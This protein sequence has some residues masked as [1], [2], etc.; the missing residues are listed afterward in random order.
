MNK[1]TKL[2][3]QTI[4]FIC[5]TCIF[6]VWINFYIKKPLDSLILAILLSIFADLFLIL[7][8]NKKNNKYELK[9][10]E[11]KDISLKSQV[12]LY[13][14]KNFVMEFFEKALKLK[15]PVLNKCKDFFYIDNENG[16]TFF[17]P[18]YSKFS[19]TNNDLLNIINN[20]NGCNNLNL[21]DDKLIIF[22]VNYENEITSIINSF[23]KNSI[24][25]FNEVATYKKFFQKLNSYPENTDLSIN[26][27][28]P[29]LSK[30]ELLNIAFNKTK[31]KH[32]FF[33]GLILLIFSIFANYDLYYVIF[34]TLLFVFAIFSRYNIKFNKKEEEP[35]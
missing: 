8:A 30:Q 11:I 3:S 17:Y 18:F 23:P 29:K 34:S 21:D 6:F 22:A 12:L 15:F 10:K 25:I 26:L 24:I 5:L 1:L 14:G 9:N 7:I 35:F 16:K 28:T 33:S 4:R 20:I 2:T 27:K 32:Y 31:S 19:L 13:S